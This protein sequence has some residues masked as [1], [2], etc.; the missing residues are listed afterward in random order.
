MAPVVRPLAILL[1][2]LAFVSASGSARA[3][4]RPWLTDV[5][6]EVRD[7][8]LQTS[9]FGGRPP[10]TLYVLGVSGSRDLVDEADQTDI[11]GS[12]T[13][14][15]GDRTRM[16][17]TKADTFQIIAGAASGTGEPQAQEIRD[18]ISRADRADITVTLRPFRRNADKLSAEVILWARNS[19]EGKGITCT[20][21]FIVQI[22]VGD[23][24]C[25][26]AFETVRLDGS[27]P[28]LEAYTLFF[29][30]CPQV[31]EVQRLIAA[32]RAQEAQA[33]CERAFDAAARENTVGAFDTFIASNPECRLVA[34]ARSIRDQ[35]ALRQEAQRRCADGF[36]AAKTADTADAYA[37]FADQS[38]Q[39]NEAA[40]ALQLSE[41]KRQREAAAEAERAAEQRAADQKAQEKRAAAERD[42]ERLE[43]ERREVERRAAELLAAEQRAAEQRA[44]EQRAAEQRAAEEREAERRTAEQQA[45]A[46][47]QAQPP[48]WNPP[49]PQQPVYCYVADVRP[50]DAW[51]ALRTHPSTR[52]GSSLRRLP[53]GTPI[54]MLG[55]QSGSWHRVR[56]QDG[57]VGWISW[58]I[59]RWIRC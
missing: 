24:Q 32:T 42:A 16:R 38:P 59:A 34:T 50:P 29:S 55:E 46:A 44:A 25:K 26:S 43:A 20:P 31:A 3:Q 15:L 49:P 22:P 57:T 53:S 39:C 54:Q 5:A 10:Q 40:L 36:E 47:R 11:L 56:I 21:S 23:P 27:I 1:T 35:L 6:D 18:L 48:A 7:L 12:I 52:R 51:L 30:H 13:A 45:A 19:A 41:L 14:E 33:T 2:L 8:A 4:D 17:I 9:C 58:E 37:R 28:K